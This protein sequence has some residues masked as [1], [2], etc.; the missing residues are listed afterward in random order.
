MELPTKESLISISEVNLNVFRHLARKLENKPLV[1]TKVLTTMQ[2]NNIFHRCQNNLLDNAIFSILFYT[3]MRISEITVLK[4]SSYKVEEEFEKKYWILKYTAKGDKLVKKV[5]NRKV[6]DS[7]NNYLNFM[8]E[9]GRE[10]LPD[11]PL[12]QPSRNFFNQDGILSLKRPISI[13]FIKRLFKK[14][15]K[16]IGIS[17]LDGYSVHSAR[18]TLITTLVE[19]GYDI[20]SVSKEVGHND[21]ATTQKCYDR[22][23]RDLGDSPLLNE[24]LYY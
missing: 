23:K 14:Y 3:G 1:P 5:L 16:E 24:N 19:K 2:V 12:L 21:V 7:I 17:N 20:Y 11:D 9:S 13:S 22:S 10:V 18:T 6:I 8:K 15:Y 4:G